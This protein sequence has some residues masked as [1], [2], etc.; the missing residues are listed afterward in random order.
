MPAPDDEVVILESSRWSPAGI[1][2]RC[3][4]VVLAKTFSLFPPEYAHLL[5]GIL[6]GNYAGLPLDMRAQFIRTGTMHLLVASGYNC[7]II[8]AIFGLL[9]HLLTVP[10]AWRNILSILLIWSYALVAGLQ[11]SLIRAAV[12]ITVFLMGY[13]LKR[14][15]DRLNSII[16]AAF[17]LL[18]IN[19]LSLYDPSFQLSF[20]AVLSIILIMPLAQP[21]INRWFMVDHTARLNWMHRVVLCAARIVLFS[22]VMAIFI[23]IGTW[24]ITAY[25]FNS[26]SAI[27]MIA[28]AVTA[29]LA[30]LLT[31]LGTMALV[32]AM[33]LPSIGHAAAAPVQ[34]LMWL[35]MK[36][37][38]FLGTCGW[39]VVY[40]RSPSPIVILIYYILLLM[41]LDYVLRRFEKAR[42][43]RRRSHSMRESALEL[44]R[45]EVAGVLCL[46]RG[47]S[48]WKK[49][50]VFGVAVAILVFVLLA[51]FR[52]EDRVL[53]VV[54]VD[55]GQ[56][57]CIFLRTPC[58]HTILM[59]GG[60]TAGGEDEDTDVGMRTVEPFLRSQGVNRLDLVVLS[61]P[62]ND[63][64][65][66]LV[67]VV[68]DWPVNMVL[69]PG[70]P[71]PSLA[72]SQFL[73]EIRANHIQ[74][75]QSVRGEVL[76]FGDGV[77]AQV[78]NPPPMKLANTGDDTNNNAIV[79]R[80]TYGKEAL[81]LMGDAGD[82]A[83]AEILNTGAMVRSD[84]LKV[85][86]HGSST[87]S[88]DAW[89]DAVSPSVG[90]ISVGKNNI[91]GHPSPKTL[92]R[93]LEHDVRVYRT[94][95]GGA[96]FVDIG[97]SGHRV[98]RCQ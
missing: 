15:Q 12:I 49:A 9:F 48:F 59:D 17:L 28:N 1:A 54:M 68:R 11:P 98:Y 91:F 14:A 73:R 18:A 81:L 33:A 77:R 61:H 88:G 8:L 31:L 71:Y 41:G 78:L 75:R 67:C 21:V 85:G 95:L 27:S 94:D 24:P 52:R 44:V 36:V 79:L 55:V 84:V 22:M 43:Q 89:L 97:K 57:D 80:F 30:L 62:H 13:L 19:P 26:V 50:L 34:G 5:S 25:H 63:H 90:M 47:F 70:I 4:S 32:L 72:Y 45:R 82:A 60:G 46:V 29:A 76:D 93:L 38:G 96:I 83:E 42:D 64:L 40:V 16:F 92:Q 23:N 65:Q 51:G 53:S 87:A 37:I 66:G 58:G 10:R 7:G 35:L 20:G 3:K 69:E 74:Y 39:S 2:S 56:G 6:L 86:H